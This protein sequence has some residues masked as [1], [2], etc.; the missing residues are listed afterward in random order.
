MAIL[1]FIPSFV[2]VLSSL[3]LL[4]HFTHLLLKNIQVEKQD[5]DIHPILKRIWCHCFTSLDVN[6]TP[7]R[8]EVAQIFTSTYDNFYISNS[9]YPGWSSTLR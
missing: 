3:A 8:N 9:R 5:G 1:T 7:V 4:A 6:V 2:G